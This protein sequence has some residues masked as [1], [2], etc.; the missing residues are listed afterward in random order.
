MRETQE[1]HIVEFI[2]QSLKISAK[3]SCLYD[4]INVATPFRWMVDCFWTIQFYHKPVRSC[5]IIAKKH[6]NY[7]G[8]DVSQ[9]PNKYIVVERSHDYAAH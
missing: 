8:F 7:A 2:L 9:T 5:F 4:I 6:R 3:E 1:T